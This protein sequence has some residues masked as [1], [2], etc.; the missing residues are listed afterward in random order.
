[1]LFCVL[2][3]ISVIRYGFLLYSAVF[4][5]VVHYG[6]CPVAPEPFPAVPNHILPFMK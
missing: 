5:Y 2:S 4:L 6:I 1:M 3:V